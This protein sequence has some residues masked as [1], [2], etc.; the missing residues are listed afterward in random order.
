MPGFQQIEREIATLSGSELTEFRR[1]FVAFDTEPWRRSNWARNAPRRPLSPEAVHTY[2]NDGAALAGFPFMTGF[3]H[4]PMKKQNDTQC[5][6][7]YM[8]CI[9]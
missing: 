9:S 3:A 1:W 2:R 8:H 6:Q 7:P 4:A 5:R